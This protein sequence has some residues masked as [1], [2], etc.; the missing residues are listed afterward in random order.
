MNKYS[1]QHIVRQCAESRCALLKI[2]SPND[3]GI[4]GT[5]QCGF[6]LPKSVWQHFTGI[7]PEKD[8]LK[9]EE[10]EGGMGEDE[11]HGLADQ[12][13]KLTDG[14]ISE[15]DEMLAQKESEITQV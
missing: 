7:S 14:S 1:W 15:I 10:K 13:Q 3:A 8:T 4:T 9:K 11:S 6:Y 2:I 12:I 5:H